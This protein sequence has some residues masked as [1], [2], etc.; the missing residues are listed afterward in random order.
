[1]E[2]P[3]LRAEVLT[4]IATG[5]K[6][7]QGELPMTQLTS[8]VAQDV[9]GDVAKWDE[10]Q[11]VRTLDTAFEGREGRSTTTDPG[12]VLSRAAGML[13][14]FKK[15]I[16][17]PEVMDQ[18]RA[19]G[20]TDADVASAEVSIALQVG[21]M[22]RRHY[23]EKVEYLVTSAL[24][25]NQSVTVGGATVTPDYNLDASH[26]I[27]V[28]VSWA[29]T[30]TDIDGDMETIKRLIAEDS[31]RAARQ[32]ICGRNIFGYL[33]KNAVVKEWFTAQSGA[34]AAYESMFGESIRGLMG[35]D[36]YT[37]LGGYIASGPTW[38]PF[39][40]DDTIIVMPSMDSGWFQRHRG[41]VQWPSS[42]Y[43][44]V[45][46][47]NKSYGVAS[48]SRLKDDPPEAWMFQRWAE[49]AIP[50]FPAAYVVADVTP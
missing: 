41:Q 44:S 6:V 14:S 5:V 11:P 35:L 21:D 27:T 45:T 33:R 23:Y 24:L 49:L 12:T 39:I 19:V 28:G 26:D 31:G 32:V 38:T 22:M 43:G 34:P 36:W 40:P 2:F 9:R 18:L 4:G 17:K 50:V 10:K 15:R 29:T 46:S 13:T 3:Q 16:I 30:T 42:V 37:Y 8:G 47:F 7:P 1:M 48:W 20:G 25:D